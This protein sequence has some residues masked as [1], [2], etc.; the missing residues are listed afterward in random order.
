MKLMA[1]LQVLLR[2]I[3]YLGRNPMTLTG[4]VLTTS[5]G[6]TLA[7]FIA[8][9][10]VVSGRHA[11]PYEGII[12]YGVLP[13]IF[14]LG[15]VLMPVGALWR[16]ITLNRKGELPTVYPTF[17][18][19]EPMIR[20]A[21]LLVAAATVLNVALL[22]GATYKGIEHMDSVEFCGLTC[23]TVMS[24]EYTAYLN[25][26]HSRITCVQCHIGPGASFF[27]KS[28]LD[29][30]RQVVATALNT[31]SRP[32]PSPVHTLRPARETCEQCHWPT[33][34]HGDKV[35]VK[36]RYA[37]DET[38]TPLTTVLV[39]RIG[40][41]G[42]TGS[43]GI[44]GRHLTQ[45]ERIHYI[46]SDE[47]REEIAVV[48][49]E[50][51]DG[52]TVEY[53]A[54][55]SKVP[56]EELARREERSM[57]CVDCHNRPTHAFELPHRAVDRAI[58]EGRISRE[59]PWIKKQAV[60]LMK[61]DYPDAETAKRAIADGLVGYYRANHP[62]VLETKRAAVEAAVTAVQDG[63]SR[64]VSPPMRLTWGSHP[65]H[66]GHEDFPGCFRCH[67]DSHKS[68]DGQVISQDCTACH[69]ILA[70]EESDPK[71]LADLG[72]A[73]PNGSN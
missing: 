18:L 32:I 2:P 37:E 43:T 45:R 34:F 8:F 4:A 10:L 25:S 61:A 67:D 41:E 54:D 42:G 63:W 35:V 19:S 21:A 6:I 39:L 27:V 22:G 30:L 15:L 16:R 5:A 57:D 44:H 33:K 38:S 48:R 65:N 64:N 71:V 9:E 14:V 59:L 29:G 31:Y 73:P 66:I 47:R 17:N 56:R 49:Y 60:E 7:V 23:H 55:G 62:E 24:P 28:K 20:N 36:T 70:M 68:A 46:A 1:R 40:G 69:A 52:T 53:V 11:R 13:V 50:K 72:L 26:P 51:G 12:L 58:R 3:A